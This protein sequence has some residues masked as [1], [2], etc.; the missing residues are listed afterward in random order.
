M[1]RRGRAK[2]ITMTIGIRTGAAA[3]GMATLVGAF[4]ARPAA[5]AMPAGDLVSHRAIYELALGKTHGK[6]SVVSARG[7]ILY[8]FSG[9]ACEGYKLGFRQ[10]LEVDNGEGK[11]SL[12]DLRSETW[13]DG[14]AKGYTFKSENYIDDRLVEVTDGRA[15]R[16]PDALGV[17]L[18][19]PSDTKVDI[20]AATVL[21]T[22]HVRRIID[23][24]HIGKS[25]LEFPVYDGSDTGQKVYN[26][27]TVI[28]HEIAP[29]TPPGD[30]AAGQQEL[31]KLPRWPVTV[32]Y[33][34]KSAKPGE[35]EPVYSL[36]YELY[37]NGVSRALLLDYRDFAISG[38]LKTIELRDSKACP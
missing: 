16:R 15:D 13:E 11:I 6:S 37:E 31:A 8:D 1:F 28:G 38:E 26:T 33:F 35:Q 30:G 4:C 22:E 3:A 9:S 18:S 12:T 17:T 14:A 25:I 36:S 19:K 32:S 7:R 23:A 21:P 24:A 29:G 20:P 34:E 10:V 2:E 5:A 27:L